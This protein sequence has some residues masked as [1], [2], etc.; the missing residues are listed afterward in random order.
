[1]NC[2]FCNTEL[3]Q[4]FIDLGH[5]PPS[6]ALLTKSQLDEPETYYPLKVMVCEKCFLVQLPESKKASEIFKEDYPYYSSQSPS[7]VSHA[8]EYVE[9][10]VERFMPPFGIPKVL[11]IGSNDGYMLQW[12]KEKGYEVQ[13]IDPSM[14]PSLIAIQNGIPTIIDFFSKD[15]AIHP[16]IERSFDLIC[17]I[18]TIAHQPEINDFVA[19]MKIALAPDGVITAEFPHLMRLVEGCQFDTIYHEH[20]SYFS[21]MTIC[22]IF[23]AHGLWVFDVEE[24]SE[25]GGSLRMYAEHAV[26]NTHRM[27]KAV[28]DLIQEEIDKGM[29]TIAYYQDFQCKVDVIKTHL[30]RFLI[31]AKM[32]GKVVVGYG[33]PAKGNTLL[34]YCGIRRDLLHYTVDRSPYKVG[35]FLPGSHIRIVSED[36]LKMYRPDYVL[37]LPWN[38]KEEIINQLSYIREWGGRFVVAIPE[39]EVL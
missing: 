18:N 14:G 28:S 25:H 17:S 4:E 10:I 9:M 19:G 7:N 39:F 5:Q 16:M 21:F 11:E 8:K 6:N 26:P 36:I 38:L 34:N 15:M 29:N 1:M 22:E 27:S 30:V 23:N 37:I 3:A 24:L 35:K 20:Y 31:G 33:A 2:R 32:D 12:F 13:G